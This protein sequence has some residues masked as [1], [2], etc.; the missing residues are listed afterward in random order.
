MLSVVF[1]LE[2]SKLIEYY[3]SDRAKKYI[4]EQDSYVK[5]GNK[6]FKLRGAHYTLGAMILQC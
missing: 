4:V 6:V 2:L 3:H 1:S 5:S